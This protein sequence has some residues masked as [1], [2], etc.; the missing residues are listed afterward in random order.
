MS[1]LQFPFYGIVPENAAFIKH[2]LRNGKSLWQI[3]NIFSK[4]RLFPTAV[5][6]PLRLISIIVSFMSQS[7]RSSIFLLQNVG[8]FPNQFL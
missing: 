4:V 3:S 5:S 8:H 6:P 7:L 1:N 2:N